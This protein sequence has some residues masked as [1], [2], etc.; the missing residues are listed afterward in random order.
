MLKEPKE[1]ENIPFSVTD[2]VKVVIQTTFQ[3]KKCKNIL[4]KIKT[5]GYNAII[6][7]TICNA[8]RERQLEADRISAISDVVIV[9]GGEH[10]SNSRRLYEIC[11][12][13]CDHTYFIQ[14]AKDLMPG[15]F[16]EAKTVGITAGASTP[17][18]IITEVQTIC[19]NLNKC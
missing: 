9:I 3:Q 14:T 4:E 18:N 10:S 13:N 15:W 6:A 7:D 16:L 8:T 11:K 5:L 2:S 17:K 1:A 19:Q 12:N